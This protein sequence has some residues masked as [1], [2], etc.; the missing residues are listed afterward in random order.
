[1]LNQCF[2]NLPINSKENV[3]SLAEGDTPPI[4]AKS[5]EKELEDDLEVYLKYE[6]ANPT[7]SFKDRGMK[8]AVSKAVEKGEEAVI[9]ASTGITSAS[10]AGFAA[11]SGLGAVG[12]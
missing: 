9:C 1:M 5:I 6:G 3:V 4:R 2:E 8:V 10:G 7:G 12:L 11:R